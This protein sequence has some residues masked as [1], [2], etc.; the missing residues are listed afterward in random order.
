M[1]LMDTE[2]TVCPTWLTTSVERNVSYAMRSG[3]DDPGREVDA[4]V[5]AMQA[6]EPGLG[7]GEGMKRVFVADSKLKEAYAASGGGGPETRSVVAV[8]EAGR[9]VDRR[10]RAHMAEH[11]CKYPTAMRA[12]LKADPDLKR[13]YARV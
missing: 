1:S 2:R 12:V 3:H 6:A 5:K 13:R 4:R 11:G 8:V 9:E 7:Y 10:A